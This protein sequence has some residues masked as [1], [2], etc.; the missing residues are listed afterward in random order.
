MSDIN[1]ID[2]VGAGTGI[3]VSESG[4]KVNIATSGVMIVVNHGSTAG[5][6]RPSGAAA[7]YWIGSATPTNAV[8]GDLW[9]DGS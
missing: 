5:T 6:A 1:L 2:A 7:V 4:G 3:A 8:N 9:N